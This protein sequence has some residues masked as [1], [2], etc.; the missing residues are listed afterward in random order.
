[1]ID[2]CRRLKAAGYRLALDDFVER[3][4]YAPLVEMADI[5]KVDVLA[6][7]PGV[8]ADLCRRYRSDRRKLLAEKVETREVL[9]PRRSAKATSSSRATSSAG[10]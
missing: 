6:T 10:R 8:R 4:D 1:M 2:A 5:L 7:P 9:E 3:P